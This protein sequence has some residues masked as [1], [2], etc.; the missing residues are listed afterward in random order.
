MP[1]N[2]VTESDRT[3]AILTHILAYLFS[4]LAPL[5]VLLAS[6]REW[7]RTH[8]RRALNWQLSLIIYVIVLSVILTVSAPLIIIGVGLVIAILAIIGMVAA[9]VLDIVFVIIAAIRAGEGRVYD[10]PLTIP[11]VPDPKPRRR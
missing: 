3:T 1:R 7:V 8:A 6:E 10:Y 11:F 2:D 5:I 4:F 9:G